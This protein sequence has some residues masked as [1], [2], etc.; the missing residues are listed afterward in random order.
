MAMKSRA[1]SFRLILALTSASFLAYFCMYAF[2]KPFTVATYPGGYLDGLGLQMKTAL[3][4]SQLCG[5]VLSKFL[6]IQWCSGAHR[7][8]RAR[9]LIGC[10]LFAEAALVIFALVPRPWKPLA[11]FANGLPLGLVWGFVIA[12]LEGRRMMEVLVAGLSCS[13]ILAGGVVKDVGTLLLR[14]GVSEL[15]MPASVGALFL[16][17]F[18]LAAW[19]LERA[20]EPT[21][22]DAAFRAPRAPMTAADRRHFLRA[23]WPTLVP[24]ILLYLLL[25]AFRDF[26]D[27]FGIEIFQQ[28]GLGQETGLFTRTEMPVALGVFA[29]M[30]LPGWARENRR[31]VLVMFGLMGAGL[32]L[33]G[34]ATL[35]HWHGALG[36]LAWMTLIG[37]GSY[38]AYVPFGALLFDRL[39]AVAR[40][41]GTALFAIYLADSIAY[42]GAVAVQLA[43]DLFFRSVTRLD[44]LRAGSAVVAIVGPVLLALSVWHFLRRTR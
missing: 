29:A 31:A 14:A 6:G 39:V 15:W 5:Y 36:G 34:L 43:Y 11:M 4:L 35:L 27:N 40:A 33:V 18:L 9:W 8:H 41:G 25:T 19:L 17:P 44:F 3:V 32:L 26:R 1:T 21:P 12:Y 22:E 42:L 20:P 37:L 23:W 16:G 7:R 13:F 30:L 38:L 28:L 2:R 24:L 10:V